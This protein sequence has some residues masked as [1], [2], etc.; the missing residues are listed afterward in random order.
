MDGTPEG[1]GWAC[2]ACGARSPRRG[3]ALSSSGRPYPAVSRVGGCGNHHHPFAAA[4]AI[5]IPPPPPP[6]PS[7]PPRRRQPAI[8][9]RT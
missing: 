5:I 4:A 8:G 2:G 1:H 9:G 3:A 7:H 6:P